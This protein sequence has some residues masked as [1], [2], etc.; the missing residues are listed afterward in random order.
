MHI[1]ELRIGN[2]IKFGND[3][4]KVTE[5]RSFR[6]SNNYILEVVGLKRKELKDSIRKIDFSTNLALCDPVIIN[7]KILLKCGIKKQWR[8][9]YKDDKNFELYKQ[10]LG[11]FSPILSKHFIK[12][13]DL[14]NAYYTVTGHNLSFK[15]D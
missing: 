13:H 8:N 11:W 4:C 12:L 10:E 7:D 14:Q 6:K 15:I 2:V 3:L 5:L 1:D 9:G